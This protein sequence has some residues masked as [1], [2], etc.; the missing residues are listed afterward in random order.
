MRAL[1]AGTACLLTFLVVAS[2]APPARSQPLE[3]TYYY[4]PG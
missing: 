3:V 4:L 2:C 1:T